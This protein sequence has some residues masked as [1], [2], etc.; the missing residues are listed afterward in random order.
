MHDP[1]R[2]IESDLEESI[3]TKCLMKDD[4]NLLRQITDLKN[5]CVSSLKNKGKIIFA[6][7][8]GSFADAQHLS[9]EFVSRLDRDRAPLASVA[10]G[11]NSSTL[12]AISNDYGYVNSFSRELQAIAGES[13]VF[14]A[15]STSGNSENILAA[16]KSS[17][18]LNLPTICLTGE[19]GGKAINFCDCIKVPSKKTVRI[20]ECH[21]TL[22]HILCRLVEKEYFA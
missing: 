20:Q 17:N 8:G 22:G 7:N 12:S 19:S 13:D 9:G 21:I 5:I 18:N 14:I 1:L 15:L 11:T 16:I 4:K 6:G 3:K 10:L 2:D